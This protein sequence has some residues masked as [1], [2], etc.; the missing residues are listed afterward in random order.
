L[1][2]EGEYVWRKEMKEVGERDA[3]T[4]FSK[5]LQK[6]EFISDVFQT[7]EGYLHRSCREALASP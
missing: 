7:L 3:I 1:E 6:C 4:H 5:N 2:G